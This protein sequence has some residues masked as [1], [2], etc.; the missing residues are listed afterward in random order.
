MEE[1]IWA[2]RSD[3]VHNAKG[4][5]TL[6]RIATK[7]KLDI[8]QVTFQGRGHESADGSRGSSC[9]ERAIIVGG[10]GLESADG[11]VGGKIR[12]QGYT[13]I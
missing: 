5:V 1:K 3:R 11:D 2:I 12:I 7:G 6:P 8:H 4:L 13:N 10:F 9:H